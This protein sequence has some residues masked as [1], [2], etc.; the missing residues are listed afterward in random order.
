MTDDMD[1][2]IYT[3][4]TPNREKCVICGGVAD[5][6]VVNR[7]K[8]NYTNGYCNKCTGG[9]MKEQTQ[10]EYCKA[11]DYTIGDIG[12]TITS[13]WSVPLPASLAEE[14]VDWFLGIVRPMLISYFEHGYKH[15]KESKDG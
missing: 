7:G 10:N 8:E 11:N 14:H 9:A 12:G 4:K 13:T 15:G 2:G 6:E 5:W 1:I 3:S